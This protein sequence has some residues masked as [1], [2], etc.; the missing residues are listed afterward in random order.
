VRGDV[1]FL[2]ATIEGYAE[3]TNRFQVWFNNLKDAFRDIYDDP[4][5]EIKADMENLTF[6]VI[7]KE[8]N[9]FAIQE[10]SDGHQA[11]INIYMELLMRFDVGAC[12]VD[13]SKS[14]IVLIDEIEAHMHVAFQ[15]KI[16]PFFIKV[17]PNVQFIVTTHSPF[18]I[19]SIEQAVVFDLETKTILEN[20]AAYPYDAIIEYYLD[21]SLYSEVMV[22]YFSRYKELAFK[23]RTVEEGKEFY[24][25]LYELKKLPEDSALYTAFWEMESER[26]KQKNG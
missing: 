8:R 7:S 2:S 11:F 3:K 17:F 12:V 18:V 22:D 10:M 21:T 14:A 26:I 13:Y 19:S 1:Q 24:V 20:P 4:A 9:P 23:K 15:R 16:L 6:M 5:L 25:A